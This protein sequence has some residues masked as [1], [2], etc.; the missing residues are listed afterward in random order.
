MSEVR[1]LCLDVDGVLTDGRIHVHDD[2]A[3]TRAFHVHDGFAI[4]WFQKL[5]G[6][7]AIITGKKSHG[8]AHRARELDIRHVVQGSDDKLRDL[9]RLAGELGIAL[10]D[11]AVV[12]DDLP[13]LPMLRNCGFPIAVVNAVDAVKRAARLVTQA[14][15]GDGAVR[16]AIEWLMRRDGRW[17][18]VE[19]H[20]DAQAAS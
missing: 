14:R 3:P 13:D 9:R 12:G 16:E 8:V 10:S 18:A 7:A 1:L 17:S 20:Y 6:A 2:G 11:V 19:A 15:G 5:G 4:R